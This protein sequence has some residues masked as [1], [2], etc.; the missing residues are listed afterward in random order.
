MASKDISG[1]KLAMEDFG[2][3]LT[4]S[5]GSSPLVMSISTFHLPENPTTIYAIWQIFSL[6]F[7]AV[8]AAP[9]PVRPARPRPYLDF[10]K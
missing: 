5:S 6:E 9:Y 10:E 8:S 1:Q 2:G 3:S 7:K 4:D